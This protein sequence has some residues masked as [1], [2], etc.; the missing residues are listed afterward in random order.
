MDVLSAERVTTCVSMNSFRW[1]EGRKVGRLLGWF[2]RR[3]TKLPAERK[4]KKKKGAR[5][6]NVSDFYISCSPPW[7][8]LTFRQRAVQP[9][10]F[11]MLRCS[12]LFISFYFV[13]F[14]V[15]IFFGFCW[16][17]S[18]LNVEVLYLQILQIPFL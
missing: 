16:L 7:W 8:P 2:G 3:E 5:G 15:T 14:N 13:T 11:L 10:Y 6:L 4:P 12:D 18:V 17:F 9:L 1:Q